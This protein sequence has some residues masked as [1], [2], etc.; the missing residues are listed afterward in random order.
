MSYTMRVQDKEEGMSEFEFIDEE[1]LLHF[2]NIDL[3]KETTEEIL[4]LVDKDE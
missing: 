4:I 2:L 1:N 3:A